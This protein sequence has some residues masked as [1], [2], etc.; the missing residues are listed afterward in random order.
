MS[1][2][3][4]EP[5]FEQSGELFEIDAEDE[6]KSTPILNIQWYRNDQD[7]PIGIEGKSPDGRDIGVV[8]TKSDVKH[9]VALAWAAGII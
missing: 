1:R 2:T 5:T 7:Y 8:L 3:K 6:Y 4:T 9:I